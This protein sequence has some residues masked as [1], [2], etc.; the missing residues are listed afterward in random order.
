MKLLLILAAAAIAGLAAVFV[1]RN[2][3]ILSPEYFAPEALF[4]EKK[5]WG[6]YTGNTINSFNEFQELAGKRADFAAVFVGWRE[7]FPAGFESLKS[8][9]QTLIVFWEPYEISLDGILSG[10]SDLYIKQFSEA[11]KKYGEPIILVPFH[12]MNGEWNPWSGVA[13]DNT[14]TKVIL[15]WRRAHKFFEDAGNVKWGWAVN[16]ESVPDTKGNAIENY[17][18]GDEYVD[19]VGVDGFNFGEPWQTYSEIFSSALDKL[20]AY[21]KPIYIFSMASAEGPKKP[22]WIKDALLEINSDKDI[23]GWLWFNENKEKNWLINSDSASLQAF[24][25]GIR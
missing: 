16:H 10:D 17:Y 18:P 5:V 20:R 6:A 2:S 12:E 19:Y 23:E 25:D 15:A 4:A 21:K 14:P 7:Q 3:V 9:S 24:K 11:S 13:G 1:V 8:N 22:D